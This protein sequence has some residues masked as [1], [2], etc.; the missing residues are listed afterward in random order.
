M[1]EPVN[2]H[3]FCFLQSKSTHS[4]FFSW[5]PL[6]STFSFFKYH[7]VKKAFFLVPCLASSFSDSLHLPL[8]YC[9]GWL[10]TTKSASDN[11][12]A[13]LSPLTTMTMATERQMTTLTTMA[14][15][16]QTTT[17]T[18]MAMA[19]EERGQQLQS[20]ATMPVPWW[21]RQHGRREVWGDGVLRGRGNVKRCDA[22]TR[23]REL[24]RGV[25]DGR[26]RRLHNKRWHKAEARD[27]MLRN[28]Q[29]ADERQM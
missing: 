7:N 25:E 6:T 21:W 26:L 29:P 5:N 17:S 19:S 12:L 15:A 9:T 24:T 10:N 1:N 28:N 8:R 11:T 27:N 16:R 4:N 2:Y 13:H 18:T 22:T 23:W 14:M 20:Q 3:T